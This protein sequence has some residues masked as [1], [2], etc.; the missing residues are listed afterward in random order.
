MKLSVVGS[1]THHHPFS[2]LLHLSPSS[3][4]GLAQWVTPSI[5]DASP[6]FCGE[7]SFGDRLELR[8]A[9]PEWA[10]PGLTNLMSAE[11][12][13][14]RRYTRQACRSLSPQSPCNAFN[15]SANSRIPA[16]F[17]DAAGVGSSTN[18]STRAGRSGSSASIG[19]S[20]DL[21]RLSNN[22][23]SCRVDRDPAAL[24]LSL[25][26][27]LQ[28]VASR[29]LDVPQDATDLVRA[30][31]ACRLAARSHCCFC[32]VRFCVVTEPFLDLHCSILPL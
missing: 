31:S 19:R 14:V 12:S 24:Q 7:G 23:F 29:L 26:H 32:L 6:T 1:C 17:S 28:V 16:G 20:I 8:P 15:T 4:S 5:E 3:E 9:A 27:Q 10:L 13:T 18:T 2:G 25:E 22:D 30:A 21:H 11:R